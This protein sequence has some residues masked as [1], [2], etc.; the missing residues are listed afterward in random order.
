MKKQ[1]FVFGAIILSVSGIICKLLG[2]IYKIP[3]AHVLGTQGMGVY[4]IIFPVYA[5]LLTFVSSSFTISVSKSISKLCADGEGAR[6]HHIFLAS[7]WLLFALGSLIAVCVCVF[8]R[9][10]ASLQGLESAYLCYIAISPAIICVAIS[11][12][13]KG[14]F[15]GLQNMTPTAVSN[16]VEQIVKLAFGFLLAK[17]LGGA[18]VVFGALGAIIG[19]SISEVVMLLFFVIYYF[20]FKKH[21]P[22]FFVRDKS[23]NMKKLM[24]E[25]F[26]ESIPFTLTSVILPLSLVVDSF[27]IVNVLKS[28]G[29]DKLFATGLLGLNS[30]VVSTLINLPSTISISL[31]MTVVPYIAFSLSKND[32]EGVKRKTAFAIKITLIIAVP[33]CFAFVFFAPEVIKTLYGTSFSGEAEI[34]VASSL[35]AVS[36]INV[37]YLSFLQL[38]TALLQAINKAYVPVISLSFALI[39]KVVLEILLVINPSVNI[40]GVVVSNSACYFLATAINLF[41]FTKYI[42]PNCTFSKTVVAPFLSSVVMTVVVYL[43]LK[44]LSGYTSV[45]WAGLLSFLFGGVI[46]F[47][48]VFAFRTFTREEERSLIFFKLRKKS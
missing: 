22:H 30:G 48:C 38:S 33:F 26:R 43:S 11:S 41:E 32:T 31:C 25:V 27:L 9:V 35:L 28:M 21:N 17:L 15:Q 39:L 8:S 14:L 2:V 23:V 4:Y 40:A 13:F 34:L 29:F 44:I 5:F 42:K 19:V 46:Y 37:L 12:A 6:A 1:S 18:G 36:S 45:V 24:K 20:I 7:L 47:I 10:I 3:L 16:I